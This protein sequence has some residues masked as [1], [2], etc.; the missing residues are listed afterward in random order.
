[1]RRRNVTHDNCLNIWIKLVAYQINLMVLKAHEACKKTE[2]IVR[3][4]HLH[5]PT[6]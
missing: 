1:M 5:K 4:I 6:V 2:V 3:V